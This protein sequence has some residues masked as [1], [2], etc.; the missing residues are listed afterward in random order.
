MARIRKGLRKTKATSRLFMIERKT[1][2]GGKKRDLVPDGEER[3]RGAHANFA[4]GN[5]RVYFVRWKK[6]NVFLIAITWRIML[7]RIFSVT[8]YPPKCATRYF[9]PYGRLERGERRGC[10]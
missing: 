3:N 9:D 10:A 2:F 7:R 6:N 8:C 1:F 5:E 4:R